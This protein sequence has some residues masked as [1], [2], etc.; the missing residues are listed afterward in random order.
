MPSFLP[1]ET[2]LP[3]E[4]DPSFMAVDAAL[5]LLQEG[6]FHSRWNI[7]KT[8]STLGEVA[9]APLLELLQTEEETD[10]E[11]LWFTARIL[12]N[13]N[14]ASALQGLTQ[15][16][17][18]TEHP[19]VAAMAISALANFGSQAIPTLSELLHQPSTR[20][21]AVSTLAQLRHPEVVPL[22]LEV[23]G[24]PSPI[25]RATAVEA[26]SH[27]YSPAIQAALFT[28]LHDPQA[29][30]RQAAVLGIGIQVS[31]SETA[32]PDESITQLEP[33]L[34]DLNLEVCRQTVVALA[35]IGN[36]RSVRL[37]DRVLQSIHTPTA[38][39]LDIIRNLAW[40]HHPAA[41]ESL[42]RFLLQSQLDADFAAD[43][44]DALVLEAIAVLGR[45]T[46]AS[47][48]IAAQ[49]LLTLLH[50][51][52][53][54]LQT[55]RGKQ[56]MIFSLGQLQQSIATESLIH[57]LADPDPG[58]RFHAIAALKQLAAPDTLQRLQTAQQTTSSALQA[59]IA[60]ALQEWNLPASAH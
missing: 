45:L 54:V 19:D 38:L 52:H 33:L 41:L 7:A 3:S 28:A 59:G 4:I 32:D 57:L 1:S 53:P 10:W 21:I 31:Q 6:D 60:L 11:L 58:V 12:G 13:L 9:V 2:D 18:Q 27:F 26:L 8:L 20:Q 22:L 15:I 47:R 35:R 49:L 30:V 24:D 40:I 29:A 51:N 17:H 48:P 46:E 37:L 25:I 5:R 55:A 36:E 44:A 43:S 39:Q 42:R 23:L 16:L 56:Q 34:W 50:T 14:C